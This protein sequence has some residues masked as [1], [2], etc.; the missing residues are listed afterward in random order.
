[1]TEDIRLVFPVEVVVT[2]PGRESAALVDEVLRR[3]DAAV[4]ARPS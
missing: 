1:M 4:A 2:E 3:L